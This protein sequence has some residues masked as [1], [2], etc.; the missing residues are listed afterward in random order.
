MSDRDGHPLDERDRH[1]RAHARGGGIGRGAVED[2]AVRLLDERVDAVASRRARR[3]RRLRAPTLRAATR[4]RRPAR[5]PSRRRRRRAA[6]RRRSC[7]RCGA[8]CARCRSRLRTRRP[9][10]SALLDAE[11]GLADA[12]DVAR[13]HPLGADDARA[14]DE[15]AVRRVEILHPDAVAARLDARVARGGELVPVEDEV[16]LAAAPDGDRSGVERELR[17]LSRLGLRWTTSCT[18]AARRALATEARG[19]GGS[20]A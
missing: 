8:A 12:E 7:P 4:P 14:V 5:R 3:S 18:D 20:R 13:A 6:A 17:A 10:R 16:V 19:C 11:V 2:A 9:A 1:R 15:R